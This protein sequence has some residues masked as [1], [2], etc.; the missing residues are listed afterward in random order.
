MTWRDLE[1]QH[2]GFLAYLRD[3]YVGNEC[4]TD[5]YRETQPAKG[6]EHIAAW[7][8]AR[9]DVLGFEASETTK[10]LT[11][12]RD[13]L[14][15]IVRIHGE[16]HDADPWVY[17]YAGSEELQPV[18]AIVFDTLIAVDEHPYGLSPEEAWSDWSDSFQESQAPS[19]D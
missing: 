9:A 13:W 19:G 12:V 16:D 6:L 3:L 5:E 1:Q 7:A 18:L 2:P 11:L 17:S 14:D 4:D 8:S 10:M 15:A